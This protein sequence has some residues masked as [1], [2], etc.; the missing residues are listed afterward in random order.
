ME[1][2]MNEKNNGFLEKLQKM[3]GNIGQHVHGDEFD[4]L[5]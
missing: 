2:A 1:E 3:E 5:H 4:E